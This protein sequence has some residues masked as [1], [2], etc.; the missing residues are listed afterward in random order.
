MLA[1]TSVSGVDSLANSLVENAETIADPPDAT[2]TP[3]KL[4]VSG[5]LSPKSV[6][7]SLSVK[8]DVLENS[9][10]PKL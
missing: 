6:I 1:L 3:L 4:K 5:L 8:T 2:C 9:L 10:V 7:E